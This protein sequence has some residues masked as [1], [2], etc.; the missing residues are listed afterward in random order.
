M[1]DTVDLA[2]SLREVLGR[3]QRTLRE[4]GGRMG[5]SASQS[6]ALG[7]VLRE[8]PL[9]ITALAQRQRVRSQSMGATVGVLLERGLVTVTPD[10]RDGRQKVVAVTDEA[11]VLVAEGRDAR[12]DW[13]AKRLDGLS[14]D[15]RG[16][17]A[18]AQRILDRLFS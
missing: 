16:T 10:P 9:T 11:R 15:E 1:N 7:Y 12:N 13:L 5:L 18:E 8:G 4:Q 17:L 3:A 14:P 6:E 2:Q